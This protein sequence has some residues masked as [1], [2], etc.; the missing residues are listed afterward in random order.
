MDSL[1]PVTQVVWDRWLEGSLMLSHKSEARRE[2]VVRIR[3]KTNY[4]LHTVWVKTMLSMVEDL[5]GDQARTRELAW[6]RKHY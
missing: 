5:G 6:H 2:V 3:Q 1:K 4:D